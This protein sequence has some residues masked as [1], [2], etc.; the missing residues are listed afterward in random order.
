MPI[1]FFLSYKNICD[2]GWEVENNKLIQDYK[3]W[4]P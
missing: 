3:L 1:S 4:K 2:I